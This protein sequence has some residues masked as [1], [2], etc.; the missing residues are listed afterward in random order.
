[1]SDKNNTRNLFSIINGCLPYEYDVKLLD[2]H[3][4]TNGILIVKEDSDHIMQ[5]TPSEHDNTCTV[6]AWADGDDPDTDSETYQ[7]DL[8]SPDLTLADILADIQN[9]L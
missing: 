8:D 4:R 9:R 5:I 3:G 1:M 6:L 2:D 7:W